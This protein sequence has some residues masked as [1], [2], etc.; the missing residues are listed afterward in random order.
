VEVVLLDLDLPDSRG[1]ATVERVA[2]AA[3]KVPIVVLTGH[4]SDRM[5][6]AALDRGA[7]AYLVKGAADGMVIEQ[8][9]AS[10]ARQRRGT[11]GPAR[12][13][14]RQPN[15]GA[16]ANVVAPRGAGQRVLLV[17]GRSAMRETLTHILRNHGYGVH[18]TADGNEAVEHFIAA[19]GEVDVVV[20]ELF[21]PVPGGATLRQAVTRLKPATP[22]IVSDAA[23]SGA[24][25]D[26]PLGAATEPGPLHILPRPHTYDGLLRL[27]H[28]V[29]S[30]ASEP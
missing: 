25:G 1:L 13:A 17:E 27:L 22:V 3:P 26:E 18:A 30:P 29:L 19:P 7:H 15:A 20:A 5:R 8:A 6:Q 21:L 2:K 11:S 9:V 14:T 28:Q 23:T 24:A 12:G 10:A 4:D 16:A